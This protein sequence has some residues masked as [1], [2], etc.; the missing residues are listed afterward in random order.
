MK[1]VTKHRYAHHGG[2]T[3]YDAIDG[4]PVESLPAGS[5][6]GVTSEDGEWAS[7]ITAQHDGWVKVS[8]TVVSQPYSLRASL[9]KGM[10]GLIQNYI[11]M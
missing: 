11:L 3:L 6:L 10:S 5:W 8:E 2:T 9:A 7:V 1:R 4:N